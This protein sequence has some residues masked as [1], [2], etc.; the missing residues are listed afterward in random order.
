MMTDILIG[1][2]IVQALAVVWLV[3]F[4]ACQMSWNTTQMEMNAIQNRRIERLLG[5][6]S[7]GHTDG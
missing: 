6:P 1:L 7:E 3:F 5:E 4:A 2:A